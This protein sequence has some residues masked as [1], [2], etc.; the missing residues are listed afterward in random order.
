MIRFTDSLENITSE[1]LEGFFDGWRNRP[2]KETHLKILKN[3]EFVV[4]AIDESKGK[5]VGFISAISDGV[6]C[7][8][9]PLV[10]VLAE[11]R[12]KGIGKELTT[13]LLAKLNKFYMIDLICDKSLQPFYT[14]CGIAPT[15]G[16]NCTAMMVRNNER[17]SGKEI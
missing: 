8:Y 13:R 6:L 2:S 4:L 5:V 10:E 12:K 15:I 7:A 14:S 3:S 16:E 17:Q 1:M 9:I 11:Y